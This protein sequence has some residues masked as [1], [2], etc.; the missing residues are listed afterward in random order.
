MRYTNGAPFSYEDGYLKLTTGVGKG[1]GWSSS[2]V[3]NRRWNGAIW[4]KGAD[5]HSSLTTTF[6]GG[7]GLAG[8]MFDVRPKTDIRVHSFDLHIGN[9]SPFQTV[10]V[11]VYYRVGTHLGHEDDPNAWTFLG[12]DI[13]TWSNPQ[14]RIIIP[15]IE[16]DANVGYSFYIH[17]ASYHAGHTLQYT[18]G[19]GTYQNADLSITSGVGKGSIAFGSQTIANRIWNGTIHYTKAAWT[20]LGNGLGGTSGIPILTGNGSL[21]PNQPLNLNLFSARNNSLSLLIVGYNTLYIPWKGGTL[22]PSI[23]STFTLP[24]GSL[25]WV[26]LAGDW[27]GNIPQG[28]EVFFQCWTIDPAAPQG[29]SASNALRAVSQ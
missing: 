12:N 14:P 19:R 11:D 8:N 2:P 29:M 10:N 18:D 16:L 23:N 3:A 7:N 1:D 9:W 6:A 24:T 28:T 13:K 17:L 27:P 21:L 20:D 26:F 25:G 4:Y 5:G 15:G 22:V